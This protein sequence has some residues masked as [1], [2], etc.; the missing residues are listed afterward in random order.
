[1]LFPSFRSTL[2]IHNVELTRTKPKVLQLNV[3][4]RCNQTC[5]HCHVNAG[6]NRK[7]AMARETLDCALHWL[8]ASG[9]ETLD[10]TGG[11]PELHPDF[12]YLVRRAREISS[13]LRI[14]DRCNLTILFEPGHTDLADFL[15]AQSV[16]ITASLPCY[17]EETVDAQRGDG[18]HQKSIRA[19][20]LLN[21]LGYGRSSDLVLNLVYNPSGTAL[22]PAQDALET[23]YKEELHTRFGIEFNH[24]FALANVPIARWAQQLKREGRADEY[25]QLLLD[26]FNP[27][28]IEGLMCR[29]TISVGW[30]G[31]I[32]DC[33]FNQMLKLDGAQSI[34]L[35]DIT[36]DETFARPIQTGPH[37]FACTA[38]SGSSCGGATAN[39]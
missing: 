9:I 23:I 16:E 13:T 32:Y 30:D 17:E 25:A 14:I 34:K 5:S 10:I 15:A 35:W 2:A 27:A 38:G 36:P 8:E 4:A 3:G 20:Q 21:S 37:C 33:D 26:N 12:R 28:T 19:L 1:M 18:V 31:A 22:P 6:P 11:A 29:D 39:G 7:E 24:L